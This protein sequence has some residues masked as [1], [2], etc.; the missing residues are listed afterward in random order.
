MHLQDSNKNFQDKKVNEFFLDI[1][2]QPN[3]VACF[4]YSKTS[5]RGF[6]RNFD[7]AKDCSQKNLFEQIN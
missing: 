5:N 2:P 6:S 1:Y 7:T 3:G 4:L